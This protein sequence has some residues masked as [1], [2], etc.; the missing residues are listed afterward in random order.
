M[1]REKRAERREGQTYSS[2]AQQ[3]ESRLYPFTT[4]S[5]KSKRELI[6]VVPS[7]TMKEKPQGI[8]L[9][10]KIVKLSQKM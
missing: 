3:H 1:E 9:R 10:L 6:L 8:K 7:E 4:V 2:V 5:L